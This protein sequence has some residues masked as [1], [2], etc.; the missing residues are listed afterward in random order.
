MTSLAAAHIARGILLEL[1]VR[2]ETDSRCGSRLPSEDEQGHYGRTRA[3]ST[4]TEFENAH[5][6]PDP[7]IECAA[8]SEGR[9]RLPFA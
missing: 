2:W 4:R 7:A 1:S 6:M 5:R 3:K 9:D 8:S